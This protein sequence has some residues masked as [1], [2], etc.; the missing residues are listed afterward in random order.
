MFSRLAQLAKGGFANPTFNVLKRHMGRKTGTKFLEFPVR[1]PSKKQ[2]KRRSK[3]MERLS[4][5]RD[6]QKEAIRMSKM[7]RQYSNPKIEEELKAMMSSMDQDILT[8]SK[9]QPQ[10]EFESLNAYDEQ[11]SSSL[12]YKVHGKVLLMHLSQYERNQKAMVD[13]GIEENGSIKNDTKSLADKSGGNAVTVVQGSA[14]TTP[15]LEQEANAFL[16]VKLR[17]FFGTLHPLFQR[18]SLTAEYE[19]LPKLF[20][21]LHR[22]KLH[23]DMESYVRMIQL[24]SYF[25]QYQNADNFFNEALE[26]CPPEDVDTTLKLWSVKLEN[27]CRSGQ[28]N[29][30]LTTLDRLQNTLKTTSTVL[31]NPLLRVL[32]DNRHK[33]ESDSFWIR[34]HSDGVDLD[35]ES[36]NIYLK[37]LAFRGEVERTFFVFREMVSLQLQPNT[38]SFSMLLHACGRAPW[39]V[40]G[41][42]DIVFDALD[43]MEAAEYKPNKSIYTALINTFAQ[44]GD[45]MAAEYYFWEMHRKGIQPDANTFNA[46]LEAYARAQSVGLKYGFKGRYTPP[47]PQP[48]SEDERAMIE[49]GAARYGK[50]MAA[51]LTAEPLQPGRGTKNELKKTILIDSFE[52]SDAREATMSQIRREAQEIRVARRAALE[53]ELEAKGW[54]FSVLNRFKGLEVREALPEKEVEALVDVSEDEEDDGKV[55]ITWDDADELEQALSRGSNELSNF[56]FKSDRSGDSIEGKALSRRYKSKGEGGAIELLDEDR[57]DDIDM[58]DFDDEEDEDEDVD[59]EFEQSDDDQEEDEEEYDEEDEEDVEDG[60]TEEQRRIKFLDEILDENT[61]IGQYK[62]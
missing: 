16:I 48:M 39:H 36:F 24:F 59:E 22:H 49:I 4:S 40:K 51:G 42:E 44:P 27:L 37:G 11:P 10:N 32:V 46:L 3:F 21:A 34:M 31:Y 38:R 9:P 60:L 58:K 28:I 41:Y 56:E 6:P 13:T 23:I 57:I 26:L 7:D 33:E 61:P 5:Q 29:E 17:K 12:S 30:A 47:K 18:K 14:L 8:L 15:E 52:D 20:T 55:R 35:V 62:K 1:A 2:Q 25:G 54:E 53:K 50:L 45:A 43:L 19:T